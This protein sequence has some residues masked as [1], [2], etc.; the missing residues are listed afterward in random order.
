[1]ENKPADPVL[2]AAW[3]EISAYTSPRDFFSVTQWAGV[4]ARSHRDRLARL[5]SG[6]SARRVLARLAECTEADVRQLGELAAINAEQAETAFRR[7]FVVNISAPFAFVV[8]F[9][10]LAPATFADIV[11]SLA[12][13]GPTSALIV[14]LAALVP[15][16]IGYTYLR[17]TDARDLRDLV[18][19]HGAARGL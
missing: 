11:Q 9:G 16:S 13:P 5:S 3:R 4:P 10:Q 2:P 6:K 12:A 8:A 7:A 15:L 18:R 14:I 1:M 17:A 19:L